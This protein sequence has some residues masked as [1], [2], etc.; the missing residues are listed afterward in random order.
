M[1]SQKFPFLSS[2]KQ[3][4]GCVPVYTPNRVRNEIARP[5]KTTRQQSYIL[6]QLLKQWKSRLLTRLEVYKC[7]FVM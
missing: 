4:P 7:I 5:M 2:P 6:V 3:N 1:T